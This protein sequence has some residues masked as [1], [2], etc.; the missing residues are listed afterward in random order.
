LVKVADIILTDCL[1]VILNTEPNLKKTWSKPCNPGHTTTS[2]RRSIEIISARRIYNRFLIYEKSAVEN[3][4]L[5][6]MTES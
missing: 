3:S 4:V 2:A 1:H 5:V 6:F